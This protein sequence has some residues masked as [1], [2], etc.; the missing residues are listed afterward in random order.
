MVES[1]EREIEKGGG[2]ER[3]RQREKASRV[4]KNVA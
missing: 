1:R 3:G 2:G 4:M